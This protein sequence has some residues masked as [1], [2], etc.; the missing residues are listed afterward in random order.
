MAGSIVGVVIGGERQ[1][2]DLSFYDL[3]EAGRRGRKGVEMGGGA[4]AGAG[5]LSSRNRLWTL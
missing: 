3:A 5:G 2:P 1:Y 4:G